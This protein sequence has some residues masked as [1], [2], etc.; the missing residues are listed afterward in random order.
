M[1]TLVRNDARC[2]HCLRWTNSTTADH[3]FPSSW[4][5]DTT[6]PTVQRW[7][8]PSCPECNRELGRL[9]K[10][11]LIRLVLCVDSKSEA[12]SG[13]ASRA[14]RSLGIDANGLSEQDRTHRE[15]L[16]A[17]I[18]S[19]LMPH[20]KVVGIPGKIPGLGPPEGEPVQWAIPIPWAGLAIIA[21]KI[22][23][24]CEYKLKGRYLEEPYGIRIFLSE[25]HF[26]PQPYAA[27]AQ[28]LDFGPGCNISRVFATEDPKVVLYWLSLWNT[29]HFNVKIDVEDELKRVDE[30]SSRVQGILPEENWRAMRIADYLRNPS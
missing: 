18:R 28:H 7:T 13:L 4:Y 27:A 14:L 3:V 9:E 30:K 20:T 25:A 11:L 16:R 24:G 6:P 8:V 29:L 10:D 5:P 1:T 19:E 26:L 21:E 15:K 23:R 2:I 22:V 12:A 17:K